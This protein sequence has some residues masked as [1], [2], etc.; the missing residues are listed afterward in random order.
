MNA[1]ILRL[2]SSAL[3]TL[4]QNFETAVRFLDLLED[5]IRS[6]RM[7]MAAS[8][9]NSRERAAY[10]FDGFSS[11]ERHVSPSLSTRRSP[12]RTASSS[13]LSDG[14]TASA[15]LAL[16]SGGLLPSGPS[17][18]GSIALVSLS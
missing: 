8:I 5:A 6:I 3:V 7:S 1:M 2:R 13:T 15:L 16:A 12:R 9:N 10:Y 17:H 18:H 4:P 14:E 11:H